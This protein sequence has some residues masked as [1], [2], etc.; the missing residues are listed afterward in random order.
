MYAQRFFYRG[1]NDGINRF[2]V[3]KLNFGFSRMHVYIDGL[4]DHVAS[5]RLVVNDI[6][7]HVMPLKDAPLGYDV[8]NAKKDGC[9]KVVLKPEWH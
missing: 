9:V 4:M 5:G 1:L 8:F 2:F 6:I 3:F 7:T